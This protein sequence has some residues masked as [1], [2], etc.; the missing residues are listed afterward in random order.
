MAEVLLGVSI[1]MRPLLISM[2]TVTTVDIHLIRIRH[3]L[4]T[5]TTDTL[6]VVDIT[7]LIR[8]TLNMVVLPIRMKTMTG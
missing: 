5:H 6:L 3:T 4:T 1:V 2:T 8:R 7:T